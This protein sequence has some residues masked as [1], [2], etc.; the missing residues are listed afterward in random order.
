MFLTIEDYKAV[1]DQKGLDLLQQQDG[2]N[3]QRAEN[4]AIEEASSYLR[5]EYNTDVVFTQQGEARNSQMVM[6]VCDIALYHL[7]S[8]LPQRQGFEIRE[9]RY[10]QAI[11]WLKDVQ[12]GKAFPNIPVKTNEDGKEYSTI[13]WGSIPKQGYEW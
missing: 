9:I 8:R 3:R 5:P 4:Y 7:V 1:T 10:K 11:A 6:I 2:E 13:R 12:A